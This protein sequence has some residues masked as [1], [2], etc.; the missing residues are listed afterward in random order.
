MIITIVTTTT[1]TT[2][3]IKRF[4]FLTLCS[5][6]CSCPDW[7]FYISK[8]LV[9]LGLLVVELARTTYFIMVPIDLAMVLLRI[10]CSAY[11]FFGYSPYQDLCPWLVYTSLKCTGNHVWNC[12]ASLH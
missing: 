10:C 2:I 11:A 6:Y 5:L 8:K 7:A 1:I 4:V 12:H 9:V 3:I